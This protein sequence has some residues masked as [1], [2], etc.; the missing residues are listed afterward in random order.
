MNKVDQDRV[1][2]YVKNMMARIQRRKTQVKHMSMSRRVAEDAN[3]NDF[4]KLR[5]LLVEIGSVRLQKTG[6]LPCQD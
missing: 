2:V 6:D 5:L 1:I 3:A 4:I